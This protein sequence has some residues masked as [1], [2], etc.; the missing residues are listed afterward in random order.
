MKLNELRP[1]MD[2]IE[3]I[4]KLVCRKNPREIETTYGVTHCIVDGEVE[5]ESG[6][7]VLTVWNEKIPD[8]NKIEIGEQIQILNSFVT[9]FKGVLSLNIGRDTLIEKLPT[10]SS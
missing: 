10:R 1:G 3:I 2:K 6:K 9:S 7:M 4:V 5:D 8:I